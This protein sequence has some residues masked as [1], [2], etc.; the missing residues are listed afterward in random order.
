MTPG[1]ITPVLRG[2]VTSSLEPSG[3]SN[4]MKRFIAPT[5]WK[6]IRSSMSIIKTKIRIR[7]RIRNKIKMRMRIISG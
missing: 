6:R 1:R 2:G 7:I 5:W 3:S 4:R